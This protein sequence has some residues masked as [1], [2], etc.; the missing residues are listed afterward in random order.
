MLKTMKEL[1]ALTAVVMLA[2]AA[3]ASP[4]C[5][6]SVALKSRRCQ[7]SQ[8][9]YITG[10]T[11]QPLEKADIVDTGVEAGSFKTLVATVQAAGVVETVK[12]DV[13]FTVF[14]PTDEAFAKRPAGTVASLLKPENSAEFQAILTY[15]AVA[16]KA[17][18][19]D[20]V[21]LTGAKTVQGPPVDIKVVGDK[22][23]ASDVVKISSAKTVN[24]KSA[25]VEISDAG[26]MIHSVKVVATDIE[27]SNG[28][29][30]VID[31]VILP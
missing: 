26:V 20:V 3:H 22:V 6:S 17:R 7:Q 24:V 11:A 4:K 16:G 2:F 12:G 25:S 21:K 29:I 28:V 13:P 10:A 27:S 18:A 9:K 23:L 1:I 8:T 14:A 5:Q 31:S 19:S 30:H 15:H